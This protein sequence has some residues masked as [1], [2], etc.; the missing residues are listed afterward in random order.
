MRTCKECKKIT[1]F[2]CSECGESLCSSHQHK[3]GSDSFC[4]ECYNELD[5]VCK[6]CGEYLE[7]EWDNTGFSAPDPT[8]FEMIGYKPCSCGFLDQDKKMPLPTPKI[9]AGVDLYYQR[10]SKYRTKFCFQK[11]GGKDIEFYIDRDPKTG[12]A[13]LWIRPGSTDGADD[14]FAALIAEWGRAVVE[15]L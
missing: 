12:T 5:G 11:K 4:T 7:Q 14:F 8:N 9:E 3:I 1:N 15:N 2:E 13:S 6:G 10:I